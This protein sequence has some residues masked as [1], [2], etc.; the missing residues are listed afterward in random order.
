LRRRRVDVD[1]VSGGFVPGI[2]GRLA[3]MKG[4]A[5]AVTLGPII[6]VHPGTRLSAGLMRHE[7]E[8]VRQWRRNPAAFPLVYVWHHFRHGYAG[9][10]YEIEA[11]AAEDAPDRRTS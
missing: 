5:V 6:I 11:R 10:P 4:P 7:L 9:N 2:G 3:G 8:H 1:S